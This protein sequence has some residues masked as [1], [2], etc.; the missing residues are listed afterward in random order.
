MQTFVLPVKRI[1]SRSL[2]LNYKQHV[3]SFRI[4]V[5][6]ESGVM[7]LNVIIDKLYKLP[8]ALA[9]LCSAKVRR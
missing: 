5:D 4:G 6:P 1:F 8:L 3:S 7:C 2:L 9:S